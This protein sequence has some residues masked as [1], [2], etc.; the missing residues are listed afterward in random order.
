MCCAIF[1]LYLLGAYYDDDNY[2]YDPIPDLIKVSTSIACIVRRTMVI[3]TR[4][5]THEI[6]YICR[7]NPQSAFFLGCDHGEMC[8]VCATRIV[9]SGMRCPLCR[10]EV[11][12]FRHA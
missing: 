5:H 1:L 4:N 8:N 12:A 2:Y 6:C 3:V 11:T 7:I 10:A 9:S